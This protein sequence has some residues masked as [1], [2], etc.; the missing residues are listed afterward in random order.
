MNSKILGLVLTPIA[1]IALIIA[2]FMA[3]PDWH[4]YLQTAMSIMV[5]GG[6][7]GL[8]TCLPIQKRFSIVSLFTK[9]CLFVLF[10]LA[11]CSIWSI[12][13]L[14]L[15]S[16]STGLLCAGSASGTGLGLVIFLHLQFPFPD[17]PSC[18]EGTPSLRFC[19]SCGLQLQQKYNPNACPSCSAVFKVKWM[20]RLPFY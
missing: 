14:S 8:L 12:S 13:L 1:G 19:P 11:C 5:I 7:L 20:D 16:I 9:F 2:V 3:P 10:G 18:L 6:V 17:S 15:E 4:S